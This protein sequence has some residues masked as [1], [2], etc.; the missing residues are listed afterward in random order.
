MKKYS[1]GNY[2]EKIVTWNK[3]PQPSGIYIGIFFMLLT[4]ILFISKSSSVLG[5]FMGFL[6]TLGAFLMFD[7]FGAGRKVKFRKIGK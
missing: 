6:F 7:S 2:Y 5:W 4:S 3:K 1:D